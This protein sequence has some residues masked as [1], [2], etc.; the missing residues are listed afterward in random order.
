MFENKIDSLKTVNEVTLSHHLITKPET[1]PSYVH[2][3]WLK[4]SFVLAMVFTVSYMANDIWQRRVK[5][6][7]LKI[8]PNYFKA[9]SPSDCDEF[10]EDEEHYR[11]YGGF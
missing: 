11:K 9:L 2:L 7:Q 5:Q 6:R 4:W 3:E 1:I 8:L 10:I